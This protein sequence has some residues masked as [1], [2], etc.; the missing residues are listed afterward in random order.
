M[1]SLRRDFT[2]HDLSLEMEA[3]NIHAA[4]ALQARQSLE[5]THWLLEQTAT[6]P[7]IAGVVGWAPIA[8]DRFP[9]ILHELTDKERLVGL[10][11]IVQAEPAGFLD[12]EDFNRGIAL[13]E[14]TGLSYD[15]LIAEYQIEEAVRFV[16]HHPYQRFVVDHCA[17]PRIAAG[18]LEPWRASLRALALRE[19]V[20]CKIS[21]LATEANWTSWTLDDLHP[22]LDTVLEAFGANR[23]MAGSDWPVCLVATSYT[24]WWETL[25]R[26][27]EKLSVSERRA[28]YGGV[29]H[30]FYG[31]TIDAAMTTE[32]A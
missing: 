13:L 27:T 4:V 19:N 32:A 24:R 5:E 3:A 12:R 2:A 26:Y 8:E 31:L 21:G 18:E 23:V 10:R 30:S 7:Y 22:Y 15:I 20:A 6:H 16:D 11:H 28:L 1:A 14:P 17:K 29:A 25:H 9:E